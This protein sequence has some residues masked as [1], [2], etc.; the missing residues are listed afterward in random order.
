MLTSVQTNVLK[1]VVLVVLFLIG[2]LLGYIPQK[3]RLTEAKAANEKL[4]AQVLQLQENLDTARFSLKLAS[5]RDQLT[6]IHLQVLDKNYGIATQLS[7]RYFDGV[8][9]AMDQAKNTEIRDFLSSL[10]KNRDSITAALSKGDPEVES[11]VRKMLID[12]HNLAS[13]TR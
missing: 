6:F 13:K 1:A 8:R 10:L 11:R 3:S 5:L 4:T 9:E 2:F 12:F 7:S